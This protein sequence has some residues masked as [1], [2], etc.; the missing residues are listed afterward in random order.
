[1]AIK[2]TV[3]GVYIEGFPEFENQNEDFDAIEVVTDEVI[4]DDGE[5]IWYL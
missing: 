5:I 2:L 4:T 3:K 1:M